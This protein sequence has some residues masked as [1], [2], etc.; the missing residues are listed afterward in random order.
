MG[1][2]TALDGGE[3]AELLLA[4]E[5]REGFVGEWARRRS[6]SHDLINA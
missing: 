5:T 2:A 1:M 3:S 6:L 4:E